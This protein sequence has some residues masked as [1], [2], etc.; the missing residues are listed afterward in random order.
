M[1]IH[2]GDF[3]VSNK[4][5]LFGALG[6]HTDPLQLASPCDP[7]T[8]LGGK[9]ANL[10]EMASIGLPVPAGFTLTTELCTCTSASH[11]SL[12]GWLASW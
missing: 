10:A 3:Y 5:L 11:V 1:F 6:S 2:R 7:S 12:E 4:L 8:R 9:G